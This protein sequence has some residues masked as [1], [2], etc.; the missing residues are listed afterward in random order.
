V[1]EDKGIAKVAKKMGIDYSEA[2]VSVGVA[3]LVLY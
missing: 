2:V 3:E 1:P